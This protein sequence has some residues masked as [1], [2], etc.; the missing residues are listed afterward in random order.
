MAPKLTDRR[1]RALLATML[2]M[3]VLV[4]AVFGLIVHVGP[5][6]QSSH[7]DVGGR[8]RVAATAGYL[9][10]E[11][12]AQCHQDRFD[13]FRETAH[14]LSSRPATRETV[15]GS[16]SAKSNTLVT[17]AASVALEMTADEQGCFQSVW[18]Q[19]GDQARQIRKERMDIVTGSGKL[20]QSYLFW[21]GDSIFQLPASFLTATNGWIS[22]P[23]FGDELP[24]FDRRIT[25]R[26]LV[27]HCTYIESIDEPNDRFLR[28]TLVY[29]VGCERCHGPGRDHVAYHRA[30]PGDPAGQAIVNPGRQSRKGQLDVCAQCHS[31]AEQIHRPAFSYR[32]GEDLGAYMTIRSSQDSHVFGV[33]SNNQMQQ[34]T[35]SR[36]FAASGTLTCTDCHNPHRLERGRLDVF[37]RRCLNCHERESCEIATTIGDVALRNCIDCHMPKRADDET[38]FR[39]TENERL[40]PVMM[41]D[42]RIGVFP[43]ETE[44][45]QNGS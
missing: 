38:W 39:T 2:F 43:E 36:C 42:H 1:R 8:M 15:L 30:H 31:Q 17:P 7:F 25:A 29:G 41:R 16:F 6:P 9:G 20:G 35:S 26:C 37:S 32:P 11:A 34:L 14:F 12:C 33:H 40:A 18:F 22:S 5:A 28:S 4:A 44:R 10:S 19:N 45:F 24:R 23:G 13:T 21:S 27:C 3:I